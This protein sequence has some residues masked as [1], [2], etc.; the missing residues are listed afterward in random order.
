MRMPCPHK[1]ITDKIEFYKGNSENEEF[2][3]GK[4]GLRKEI[5]YCYNKNQ[6][7]PYNRINSLFGHLSPQQIQRRK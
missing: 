3:K 4:T 5:T 7:D 2:C 6:K 1:K